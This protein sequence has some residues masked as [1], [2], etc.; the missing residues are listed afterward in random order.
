MCTSFMIKSKNKAWVAG[1]SME[2]GNDLHSIPFFVPAGIAKTSPAPDRVE[3]LTWKTKYAY[4]GFGFD[5]SITLPMI[6]KITFEVSNDGMNEM[7]LTS[8][9]LWLP[10]STYELSVADPAKALNV[11]LVVDWILGNFATCAEVEAA[12]TDRSQVEVW[13][14]AYQESALDPIHFPVYDATG[15]AIVIEFT[16][17]TVNVYPNPL[18]AA[19][20]APEFPWHLTNVGNYAGLT[21]MDDTPFEIDGA[22]FKPAGHGSGLRGIPGDFTPPSRLMRVLFLKDGAYV[23]EDAQGAR[24]LTWHILND[25]DI[26]KGVI[27]YKTKDLIGLEKEAIDYTQWALVKDL[28]NLLFGFR[29]YDELDPLW[30]DLHA[31]VKNGAKAGRLKLPPREPVMVQQIA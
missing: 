25:V 11:G 5:V 12:I 16:N 24:N 10:G 29:Y 2:F 4:I 8:G 14:T 28:T 3:G 19:T 7:G 22:T 27:R 20:N 13:S 6:G 26:A 23:P 17:N 15:K 9:G 18:L 31:L 21:P 1:R 30:I